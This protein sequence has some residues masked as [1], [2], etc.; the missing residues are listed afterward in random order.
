MRAEI[1][2]LITS[3]RES[4]QAVLFL[5]QQVL[6]IIGDKFIRDEKIAFFLQNEQRSKN[7][8]F[9]FWR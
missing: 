9:I 7:Y 5:L 1:L 2:T 3:G 4:R 6:S 8:N